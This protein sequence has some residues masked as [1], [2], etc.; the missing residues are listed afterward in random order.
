MWCAAE[1][2]QTVIHEMSHFKHIGNT[3]DNA[4]GE[5]RCINL[6]QQNFEKAIKTAD[7]V[8]EHT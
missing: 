5:S 6:A 3:N 8:T 7:S 4:Y 2:V 1:K